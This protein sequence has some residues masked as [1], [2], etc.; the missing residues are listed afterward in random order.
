VVVF[1]V[2]GKWRRVPHSITLCLAVS[3]GV[4]C[5]GAILWCWLGVGGGSGPALYLQFALLSFGVLSSRIWTACLAATLVFLRCRSLC[6][7]LRVR[8]IFALLGWG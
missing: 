7:V 4:A 3:Q 6:F 1:L 2:G 8:P 5:V